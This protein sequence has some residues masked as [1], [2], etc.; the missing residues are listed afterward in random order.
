M[1]AE[2]AVEFADPT[3]PDP[4]AGWA[5]L[6]RAAPLHPVWDWSLVRAVAAARNGAAV[7]AVVRDGDEV[8]ALVHARLI[9]PGGTVADVECP[10]SMS[11]PGV[12]LPGDLPPGLAPGPHARLDA[13]AAAF[14][15]ALGRRRRVRAVSYRQV[16]AAALPALARGVALVR[17]GDDVA[18]LRNRFGSYAEYLATLPNKRRRDQGRLVRQTDGDAG[19]TVHFGPPPERF[20][21]AAFHELAEQTDRRNHRRR[22]PPRRRWS[23]EFHAAQAAVPGARLLR[24]TAA[25]GR[26]VGATIT[27]DHPAAPLAGPWAALDPHEGG[28][29]GIWYEHFARSLRWAIESGRGGYIAGKGLMAQK[30]ELGFEAVPQF[31]VLRRLSAAGAGRATG[32]PP[33]S[34]ART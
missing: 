4:P 17:R 34:R 6:V 3:A 12:A 29:S 5:E 9:G 33:R 25:D 21:A 14:E 13:V 10:G 8:V 23:L 27:F 11:L 31:T 20:D 1:T 32:A 7:A 15:A 19:V 30:A 22:F 26:L 18:V 2:L 28:R 24:Y 16:Y